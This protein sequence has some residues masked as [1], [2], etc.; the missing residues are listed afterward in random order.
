M[1]FLLCKIVFD[2][3]VNNLFERNSHLFN[4]LFIV[5]CSGICNDFYKTSFTLFVSNNC[6]KFLFHILR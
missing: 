4:N 5:D 6:T 1:E 3:K 2:M